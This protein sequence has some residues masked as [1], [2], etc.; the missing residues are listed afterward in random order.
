M[1]EREIKPYPKIHVIDSI[2]HLLP[3]SE[4]PNLVLTSL[5]K[6]PNSINVKTI[7]TKYVS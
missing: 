4:K 1:S 2:L 6:L 3:T 5:S 7:N